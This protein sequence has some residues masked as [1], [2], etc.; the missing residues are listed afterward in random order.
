MN[1]KKTTIRKLTT[2]AVITAATMIFS[3]AMSSCSDTKSYAELLTIETHHV[4][5]YLADQRV[6][7]TMPTDTTFVFETGP[8]APYY[9]LDEDGNAYMQVVRRGTPGNYVKDD[10]IIYFRFTRY[11]LSDYKDGNLPVGDGN[12]ED[13]TYLNS[14]FRF[15]NYSLE[16][17]Y[18][19]GAGVQMPLKYLPIDCEVNI[20]IK[21]QLGFFDETAYVQ[22]FL[23]RIRYYPQQT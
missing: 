18:Q 3:G 5:N 12:D 19:W 1:Q 11:N 2:A 14:W 17:S 20:V 15:N 8:N 4:N 22:P 10:Q 6:D 7:N 23:Y 16:S 13:M 9:R 21:S